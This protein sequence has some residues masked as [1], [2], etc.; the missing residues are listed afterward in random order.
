MCVARP[1]RA[2]ESRA[3][4]SSRVQQREVYEI[5]HGPRSIS[6][7]L[8]RQRGVS[9]TALPGACK[10]HSRMADKKADVGFAGG[11]GR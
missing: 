1:R 3:A 4:R 7:D 5:G 8:L 6:C 2:P 10:E 9:N 11:F